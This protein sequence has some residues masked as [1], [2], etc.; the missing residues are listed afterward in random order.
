MYRVNNKLM[1]RIESLFQQRIKRQASSYNILEPLK[2]SSTMDE[3]SLRDLVHKF[4]QETG[5][6]TTFYTNCRVY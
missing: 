3:S 6:H 5:N 4:S 1:G 2:V